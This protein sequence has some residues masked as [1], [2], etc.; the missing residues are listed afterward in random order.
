MEPL[1]DES[2]LILHTIPPGLAAVATL[3]SDW[4]HGRPREAVEGF[5]D[6]LLRTLGLDFA[7][8]RV[9]LGQVSVQEIEVVRTIHQ[10]AT[11]AQTREIVKAIAPWLGGALTREV[12]SMNNPLGSGT[13]RVVVVPIGRDGEEGV[14]VAGSQHPGYPGEEDRLLLSVA[15]KHAATALRC[16]LAEETQTQF[17]RE[18]DAV[19]ARLERSET[20]LAATQH[21]ARIGT[22]SWDIASDQI[23][24][25]DE[26]Y[27]MFGL[28]PQEMAMTYYRV[29]SLIHPDDRGDVHNRVERAFQDHQPYEH[30]LRALHRDGTVRV[31]QA[32]AQ[33]VFD[34]D[35][36]PV[37]M[38]GTVQDITQRRQAEDQTHILRVALENAMDGIAQIDVQARYLAV[39]GAYANMLGYQPDELVGMDWLSTVHPNDPEKAKAAYER[40]LRDGKAEMEVLG[41]RKDNSSFWKQ[42]V[43]VKA[44]NPHGQWLGHY[45]FT[46]DITERKRAEQAQRDSSDQLLALSRR[47]IEVQ[48]EERRHL[49][50]EL[51]DEIG[52]VLTAIGVN[53]HAVAAVCDAAA[54]HRVEESIHTVV[55]ATEQV[56]DLSLDLRPTMLDDLGLIATLRWYADRQAQRTGI[57]VHLTAESLEV[58]LPSEL[59][60]GCFRVVQEAL[61]NVVRHARAQN[62]W[63]EFRQG[64]DDVELVIRDDGVGFDTETVRHRAARSES[65]GLFGIQERVK[66]LHGRTDIRSQPGQGTTIR[67]W[68]PIASPPEGHAS[69]EMSQ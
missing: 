63:I 69:S 45:S 39:N 11:E 44:Q 1:P 7:Y 42:T 48:E 6:L 26:Q 27:R 59:T 20:L 35:D 56:R 29:L 51:H 67:A 31:L 3:C 60:T 65:V 2:R 10:P 50:D 4:G 43:I 46:K 12:Q 41:V 55:Q 9:R 36:K 13:V 66:F 49:A 38:F 52:Q 53:L 62:V 28:A 19:V 17:L 54:R 15:A 8:L 23:V 68:F 32:R 58:R 24:W 22:W 40:M 34:D 37:R 57:A 5:T 47:V 16:Q 21:L 64:D 18:R 14:L 25:S 61:T 33:V 30:C